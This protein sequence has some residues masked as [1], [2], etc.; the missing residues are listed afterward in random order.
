MTEKRKISRDIYLQALGLFI[1]GNEHYTK[2][3][4][5]ENLANKLLGLEDGSHVSDRLFDNNASVSDF[6][7]ALRRSDIEVESA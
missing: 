4:E 2:G 3:R 5:I 7:E 6:D 1:L